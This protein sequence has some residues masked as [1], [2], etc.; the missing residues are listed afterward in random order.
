MCHLQKFQTKVKGKIQIKGDNSETKEA[1]FMILVNTVFHL[2]VNC[3]N[4]KFKQNC[5]NASHKSV[6]DRQLE[7]Q[8]SLSYLFVLA[9]KI[10]NVKL[11]TPIILLYKLRLK[12]HRNQITDQM[13]I[14]H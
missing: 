11:L 1:V 7:G 13:Q 6:T 14:V 9:R 5:Q 8:K 12:F 10:I 2:N 3:Q 4:V